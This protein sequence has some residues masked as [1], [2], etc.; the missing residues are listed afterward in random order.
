MVVEQVPAVAVVE[1]MLTG[2]SPRRCDLAARVLLGSFSVVWGPAQ[3]P[4][5]RVNLVT[6]QPHLPLHRVCAVTNDSPTSPQ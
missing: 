4:V 2:V 5:F 6:S 3:S 1:G